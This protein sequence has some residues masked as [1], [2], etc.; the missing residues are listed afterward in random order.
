[1]FIVRIDC[2]NNFLRMPLINNLYIDWVKPTICPNSILGGDRPVR[3][4][5]S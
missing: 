5:R 4:G 2:V 1:M 3:S